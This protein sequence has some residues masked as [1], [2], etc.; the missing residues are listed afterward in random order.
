MRSIGLA[1]HLAFTLLLA[2]AAPNLARA[3]EA[4]ADRC[5]IAVLGEMKVGFARDQPVIDAFID[6]H[7]IHALADTGAGTTML[8]GFT[9][10]A[11]HLGGQDLPNVRAYGVGGN[12]T[13]KLTQFGELK[14]GSYVGRNMQL[15]TGGQRSLGVDLLLGE[16]FWSHFDAEFDLSHGVIKLL[17]PNRI[18]KNEDLPYWGKPGQAYIVAPMIND[19]HQRVVIQVKLN[20]RPVR[21]E[22]DSGAQ[23]SVAT[24]SVANRIGLADRIRENAFQGVGGRAVESYVGRLD[25]FEIAGEEIKNTRLRFAD[26]FNGAGFNETG[27]M[28]RHGAEDAPEMLLGADFMRAHHI[29]ISQARHAVYI[30]YEGGPVFD[31]RGPP[32]ASAAPPPEEAASPGPSH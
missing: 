22:L 17:Q 6:G 9:A 20:G 32:A 27:S 2:A 4:S 23:R 8:S 11:L 28:L 16:D 18:C 13:I 24:L 7:P 10:S 21:A 3:A 19:G 29:L 1:S 30:T 12:T 25:S 15:Y 31:T 14:L 26:L 5:Q